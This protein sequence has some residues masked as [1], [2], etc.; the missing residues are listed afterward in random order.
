MRALEAYLPIDRR[1]A[2]AHGETIPE[3]MTGTLLFAD[4]SG[5]T[6]LMESYVNDLG[7]QRGTEEFS[8]LLNRFFDT[9]VEPLNMY[10]RKEKIVIL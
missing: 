9:L 5:F 8:H 3:H 10:R 1:Y 2:I 7:R 4:L 6:P